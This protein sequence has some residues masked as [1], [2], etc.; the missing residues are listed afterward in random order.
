MRVQEIRHEVLGNVE[1]EGEILSNTLRLFEES[2]LVSY[3]ISKLNYVLLGGWV[4]SKTGFLAHV[5]FV[6]WLT[7]NSMI[8][9][10]QSNDVHESADH[11]SVVAEQ[12]GQVLDSSLNSLRTSPEYDVLERLE[13]L[14]HEVILIWLELIEFQSAIRSPAR[15]YLF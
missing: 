10:W 12:S 2:M 11:L 3:V 14:H 1:D 4:V 8:G 13:E 7:E 9:F 5:N 6:Y 15:D